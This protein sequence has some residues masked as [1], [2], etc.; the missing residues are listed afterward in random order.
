MGGWN[1]V[2]IDLD[3]KQGLTTIPGCITGTL[4]RNPW[5][6]EEGI[7]LDELL[8]FYY[9]HLNPNEAPEHYRILMTTVSSIFEQVS[10]SK[11]Y[12]MK[13]GSYIDTVGQIDGDGYD[14]LLH[15]IKT[16]K[17]NIIVVIGQEKVYGKLLYAVEQSK[18][19]KNQKRDL[20]KL[21]RLNGVFYRNIET[22]KKE[23]I[24]KINNYFFGLRKT[25]TPVHI[26][27]VPFSSLKIYEIL[28]QKKFIS[29]LPIHI[30]LL[31]DP[32]RIVKVDMNM[33]LENT[34]LA[35]SYATNPEEVLLINIAGFIQRS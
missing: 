21:H 17:C 13:S 14:R 16:F 8:V 7:S 9:G 20:W 34:L 10:N 33:D 4:L 23:Q 11:K 22:R 12:H 26:S 1:P 6:I 2:F 27:R 31:Y 24:H 28:G 30:N 3:V 5:N 25:L 35:V 19:T 18:D 32:L 15:E 29:A